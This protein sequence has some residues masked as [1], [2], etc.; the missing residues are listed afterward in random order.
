MSQEFIKTPEEIKIIEEGGRILANILES[1]KNMVRPGISTASL[2][3]FAENEAHRL[4]AVPSFKKYKIGS[5]SYPASLCTSLNDVVVH[6]IPSSGCILKEGDLLKLDFGIKYKNLFT[7]SALTVPVGRVSKEAE[8]LMCVTSRSLDDAIAA[9]C[10]GGTIGDIG[11]AIQTIVEKEGFSVVRD[12]VGHGVGYAVHEEPSVPCFG[13][14][15]K[16]VKL[17]PGMVLAIE[18]MVIMG[19]SHKVITDPDG[20]TVRS[21]D[22]SLAAHFEH[23]IVITEDGSRILT[24]AD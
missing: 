5:L 11:Y 15:G 23:T 22:G 19:S 12:L 1:A 16:G 21:S 8:K 24:K 20:W 4:G 7:D 2:D 13:R 18:P 17:E 6:G 9:A 3:A 14:K 10:P